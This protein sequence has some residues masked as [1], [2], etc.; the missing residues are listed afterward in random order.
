MFIDVFLPI[1]PI[2]AA[3]R[4]NEQHRHNVTFS[5]LNEGEAFHRLIMRSETAREESRRTRFLNKHQ[6]SRKEEAAVNETRILA[7]EFICR[8]FKRQFDIDA[9]A[10]VFS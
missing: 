9:K 2:I 6:L 7:N 8:L 1:L 5:R 4:I 3:R 10:V